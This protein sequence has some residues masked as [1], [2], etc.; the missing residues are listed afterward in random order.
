M[1]K[2]ER[3]GFVKTD[4]CRRPRTQKAR[5]KYTSFLSFI[6][7]FSWFTSKL[8]SDVMQPGGNLEM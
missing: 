4:K 7:F 1:P 3:Y 2:R 8:A 6:F 5:F